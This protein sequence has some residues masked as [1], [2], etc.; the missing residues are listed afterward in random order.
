MVDDDILIDAGTGV[1][2]L[3]LEEMRLLRHVFLTHSHLDHI[4]SLPPLVDTLFEDLATESLL[5]YSQQT[6]LDTLKK[7]IFNW[8]IWPDF[9]LLPTEEKPVMRYREQA[10]GEVVALGQ[11]EVDMIEVNH[12]IPGVAY[13][14]SDGEHA[15]CFSGDTTSNDTLW[16]ALNQKPH[17]DLLLIECGFPE[18]NRDLALLAQH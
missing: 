1:G 17:L 7:H 13:Y 3:R 18:A 8:L 16:L 4:M 10:I 5:V 12:V 15:L 9:S 11:R 2:D 14:I 6:T